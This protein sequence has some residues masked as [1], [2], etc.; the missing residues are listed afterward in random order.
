MANNPFSPDPKLFSANGFK[1]RRANATVTGFQPPGSVDF[2]HTIRVAIVR[3][4]F[5]L[6]L[7]VAVADFYG[8]HLIAPDAPREN[9]DASVRW[10]KTPPA[11]DAHKPHRKRPGIFADDKRGTAGILRLLPNGHL[12]ARAASKFCASP[13]VFGRIAGD[14]NVTARCSEQREQRRRVIVRAGI[15]QSLRRLFWSRETA[16]RGRL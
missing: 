14:D 1:M 5:H 8:I 10:V 6:R 11:V 4:I 9:L 16:W 7:H 13:V 15:D 2:Q 12:L 3:G